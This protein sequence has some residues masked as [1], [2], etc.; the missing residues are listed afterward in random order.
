[1]PRR[2]SYS[3]FYQGNGNKRKRGLPTGEKL[4]RRKYLK[5]K[6]EADRIKRLRNPAYKPRPFNFNPKK[7]KGNANHATRKDGRQFTGGSDERRTH[8][9]D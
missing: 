4:K 9:R 5:R 8:G 1:M 2:D 6:E 3:K 7:G